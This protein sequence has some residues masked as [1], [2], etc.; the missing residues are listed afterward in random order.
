MAHEDYKAML[1]AQALSA[2]DADEARALDQHLADCAECREELADWEKSASA[3]SLAAEPAEPSPEVRRRIMDAVRSEKNARGD[4][5]S[6]VVPFPPARRNLWTSFGSLGAIAAIVLFPALIMGI[7]LLSQQ[8]RALR[9]NNELLINQVDLQAEQNTRLNDFVA[10]LSTPGAKVTGL[11]GT[12]QA[13]NAS[14]QLVYDKTGRAMLI[15]KGLVPPPP[16]KEYQLWFIVGKNPIPS[17]TFVSDKMG[18]GAVTAEIPQ[19]AIDS[20][21]FA[22]TLEPAGGEIA[23]TGAIYLQSGQ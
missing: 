11:H 14:A 10:I 16:G 4:R 9:K 22:V 15:A 8:N 20:A 6:R 17:K 21:V 3:L 13:S 1:P 2:L 19:Q 7:V 5:S 18:R 12:E 23:P